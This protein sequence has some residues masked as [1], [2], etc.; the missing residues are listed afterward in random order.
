MLKEWSHRNDLTDS[1]LNQVEALVRARLG[2]DLQ[3]KENSESHNISVTDAGWPLPG[4]IKEIQQV[5][6]SGKLTPYTY[7]TPE[8][9]YRTSDL[10]QYTVENGVLVL[11]KAADIVLIYYREPEQLI[12]DGD[13]NDVLTQWPN[14]Y[15]YGGL[16]EIARFTQ[17]LELMQ[18]FQPQY[19]R[20]VE[21]ANNQAQ[22]ERIGNA[23]AMRAI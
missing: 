16:I 20:E 22:R 11:S 18:F 17:D 13:E 3:L 12:N 9:I 19:E 6:K 10:E 7:V 8:Q 14:I 4:Y 15:L 2:R 5:Q 1:L 23:P 21:L